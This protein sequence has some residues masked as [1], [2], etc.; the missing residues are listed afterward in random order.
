V[1]LLHGLFASAH[2]NWVQYGHAAQLANA[3][4]EAIM[5][6]QRA[7]GQ[8]DTPRNPD[9]YP[10]DVLVK[11]LVALVDTLGLE[12]FDLGGF[13]LG[14]RTAARA[15]LAG[16]KPR[17]LVLGGMGLEG[18]YEWGPRNDFFIHA[19]DHFETIKEG[20]PHYPA[21][22]LMKVMQ[23]DRVAA[24]LLLVADTATDISPEELQRITMPTLVVCGVDDRNN[25]SGPDLAEALPD[26]RYV[27]IPESHIYSVARPELGEAIV[28]FLLT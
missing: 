5:P 6:D 3:G 10:R 23:A 28:R 12:E 27:A 25:G 21:R 19:I 14:S 22:H 11:D 8:S 17:R 9:A 20:D 2:V 1:V 24:R 7:H 16:L 18:I 26:G 13:S 4:F 15:V